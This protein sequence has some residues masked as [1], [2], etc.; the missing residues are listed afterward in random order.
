MRGTMGI[1]SVVH[2][3]KKIVSRP[4]KPESRVA[5]MARSV[6]DKLYHVWKKNIHDRAWPLT[7]SGM[8]ANICN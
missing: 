2:F 7:A 6:I 5:W 4:F 1:L 3:E 8:I